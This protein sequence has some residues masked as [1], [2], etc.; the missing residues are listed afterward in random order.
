MENNKPAIEITIQIPNLEINQWSGY[1]D[2][3]EIK[4]E[5]LKMFNDLMRSEYIKNY[6]IDV[7]ITN[8]NGKRI[9]Y[10]YRN[11]QKYHRW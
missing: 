8:D 4:F 10:P 5:M 2:M 1:P 3:I 11:L 9:Y 6:N 7:K